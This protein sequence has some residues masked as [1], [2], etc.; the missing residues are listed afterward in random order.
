MSKRFLFYEEKNVKFYLGNCIEVLRTL[1]EGSIDLVVTSPPYNVEIEYDSWND[2]LPWEQYREFVFTWLSEVKRVLK[3]DGRFAINVLMSVKSNNENMNLLYLYVD[4]VYKT[5]LN[6]KTVATLV[7]P[8]RNKSKLTTWGSWLS[9]SAPYIQNDTEVVII[10]YKDTWKKLS[11]GI[12]TLSKEEFIRWVSGDWPYMAETN[13]DYVASYSLFLPDA[14][15]KILSF[16]GDTV[17]DPFL[18]HGTTAVAAKALG[19]RFIGIDISENYL[20]V[21]VERLKNYREEY[22][23]YLETRK[24][25]FGF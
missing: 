9:A 4:A 24:N 12:S 19:R 14:A 1:P 7:E 18:G 5:G 11:K 23:K 6:Y 13:K 16:S 15:I 17:L 3:K 2:L 21:S 20:R 8:S 22:A 25:V 10:G